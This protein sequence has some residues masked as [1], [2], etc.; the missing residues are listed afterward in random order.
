MIC[1][2]CPPSTRCRRRSTISPTS[3]RG[4]SSAR[5][6]SLTS[7][8]R[9]GGAEFQ[10]RRHGTRGGDRRRQDAGAD[11]RDVRRDRA[12]LRPAQS[13]AQRR[14]RS[15]A[16]GRARSR[17]CSCGRARACSISAPAR[18]ILR[19]RRSRAQPAASVVGVDFAGEMLRL[20]RS[21]GCVARPAAPIRARPRRRARASRSPTRSCDAAT[22]GFGIRNVAEPG[23]R[24]RRARAR[25]PARR[26]ARHP[27]VRPAADSR[28]PDALRLVL[29]LPAAARRQARLEA[30][31]RLFV[32]AGVG[33][34]LPAAR[35][36]S[37]RIIAATGFSQVRAVP[38]TF[39]I[40][41]LYVAERRV[42]A[43]SP[44]SA[45]SESRSAESELSGTWP[46]F[47]DLSGLADCGRGPGPRYNR[48]TH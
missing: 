27:R 17:R 32:P 40:V 46:A 38:L 6:A 26:P 1:R 37:P 20:G 23:A 16:G 45:G 7:C 22:I 12:A 21:Q 14:P 33:R 25:P 48:V 39:G 42:D 34:H 2:R 8:I 28:D 4:R 41:Y 11:R 3:W 15:C 10:P 24:A 31:E 18:A 30:P 47:D 36:S 43:P 19:S 29:P 5:S 9:N 35:R 13:R 44:Q